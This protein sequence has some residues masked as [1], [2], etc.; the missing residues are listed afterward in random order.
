MTM[1]AKP[2][3]LVFKCPVTAISIITDIAVRDDDD[4]QTLINVRFGLSCPCCDTIHAFCGRDRQR[5]RRT[6]A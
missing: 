5:L 3:P 4:E 1:K 2:R 6:A